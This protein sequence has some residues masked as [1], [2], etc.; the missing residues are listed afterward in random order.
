M[1]VDD[2][3]LV[4]IGMKSII[5]WD[6]HGYSICGE[7]ANGSEAVRVAMETK[8]DIILVDIIIPEM[9]GLEFI[10]AIK[11]TL[12]SSKFI[13]LSNR[14][15]VEYYRKAISLGVSEYIVKSSAQPEEILRSV[16]NVC[17]E[18]KRERVFDGADRNASYLYGDTVILHEFM[19]QVLQGA[20]A[21][22]TIIQEKLLL[23]DIPFDKCV[24]FVCVLNLETNNRNNVREGDTK[25]YSLMGV[26]REIVRDVALGIVLR[27]FE[28]VITC[29]IGLSY[30]ESIMDTLDYIG[31]R[32]HET[33]FQLY[34]ERITIGISDRIDSLNRLS[35]GYHQAKEALK[36]IFFEGTGGTFYFTRRNI[37]DKELSEEATRHLL[38]ILSI[39]SLSDLR[40]VF[41]EVELLS[42]HLA[43][44]ETITPKRAKAIYLSILYHVL[45]LTRN[46]KL[47]TDGIPKYPSEIV[48]TSETF[49]EMMANLTNVFMTIKEGLDKRYSNSSMRLVD[50]VN[51]FIEDHV[52]M[53][54]KLEDIA[55]HVN[56]SP[57]YVSR[58]YKQKTDNT[59]HDRIIHVKIEKSKH[60]LMD[61]HT[62]A[63]IAEDLDFS[64]ESHFIKVFKKHIGTTPGGFLKSLRSY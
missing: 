4:R 9:N 45:E 15:D 58:I 21:E 2:E 62:L 12:P 27:S 56:F 28:G 22:D 13:I 48:D 38:K 63:R 14:E 16:N 19:N 30:E 33:V 18:I 50:G 52:E 23:H 36:R 5:P 7:A 29:I 32:M 55:K 34:D 35:T 44:K 24:F 37:V 42:Q 31:S 8:P 20:V 51:A 43:A 11:S 1:I 64:S 10:K 39:S 41:Q 59:V 25:I 60:M 40:D 6:E 57:S 46:V 47:E 61:G 17:R 54:I 53:K 49:G 3:P 26:L